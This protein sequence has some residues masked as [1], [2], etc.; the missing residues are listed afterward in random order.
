MPVIVSICTP[1][2][3][4]SY[5][6]LRVFVPLIVR[7]QYPFTFTAASTPCYAG[8][9]FCPST[10]VEHPVGHA[11]WHRAQHRRTTASWHADTQRTA[12]V[13]TFK[14]QLACSPHVSTCLKKNT[15]VDAS[16]P[17][18]RSSASIAPTPASEPQM[19]ACTIPRCRVCPRLQRTARMHAPTHLLKH[20]KHM[21]TH[22]RTHTHARARTH[23]R[24]ATC[25]QSV[26]CRVLLG[27]VGAHVGVVGQEAWHGHFG[28]GVL[29]H[30]AGR[31]CP[32]QHTWQGESLPFVTRYVVT[33]PVPA[34]GAWCAW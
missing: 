14:G 28:R 30:V 19:R 15:S 3:A 6:L 5:P 2:C 7:I 31:G 29:S 23:A 26:Y 11:L 13:Q 4:Y 17:A 10:S 33:L 32:L 27:D 21:R 20:K 1:Y 34:H 18:A 9:S 22:R 25:V 12:G 8:S 16:L 24:T